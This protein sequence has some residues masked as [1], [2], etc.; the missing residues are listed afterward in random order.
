MGL[1]G[2]YLDDIGMD[3]ISRDGVRV[4]EEPLRGSAPVKPER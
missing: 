2:L 3:G 4:L 1:D